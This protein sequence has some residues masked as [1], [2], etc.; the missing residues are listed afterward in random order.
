VTERRLTALFVASEAI[1]RA[2]EI[3]RQAR[4]GPEAVGT[5]VAIIHA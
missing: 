4:G 2:S 1:R 5:L 3:T